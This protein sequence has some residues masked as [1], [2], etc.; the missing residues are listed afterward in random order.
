MAARLIA[1]LFLG[2]SLMAATPCLPPVKAVP[3][4]A[5]LRDVLQREHLAQALE[6]SLSYLESPRGR[7]D[8]AKC[9]APFTLERVQRTLKRLQTL[10]R[11][12]GDLD[13]LNKSLSSEFQWI[14]MAGQ[15]DQGTVA[16]TG[17]FTPV[18]EASRERGGA[19]RWPLYSR[20]GNLDRWPLPHP[21]R[22][23]LEG[24]DGLST[25]RGKLKGLEAFWLKNRWDAY[26]IQVQGSA[27]LRMPDGS[28]V[29]V[30]FHGATQYPYTPIAFEMSRDRKIQEEC[31]RE[32][33]VSLREHFQLHPEDMDT[34][35]Q[36]NNRFVFFKDI[37]GP[38]RGS[39]GVP[40]TPLRTV[41][42]DRSI[43]PSGLPIL[44]AGLPTDV[45]NR[46][47]LA[48]DSGSAIRGPGRLD[49][50]CG[51]GPEAGN[52]AGRLVHAPVQAYLM[53]I[54]EEQDGRDGKDEKLK[55]RS[56]S[57]P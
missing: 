31:L 50:Y 9:A 29:A 8:Y 32:G 39:L 43:Y 18:Y 4:D 19:Y 51:I 1:S 56:G 28:L 40:V 20:P 21:T 48:Q 36:R 10:L 34:Y 57:K 54:R 15:D 44:L 38:P 35:V 13:E 37:P 45:P 16:L 46:L 42:I 27:Q 41:A 33:K 11:R 7:R 55:A 23:E 52:Q 26:M 24:A 12:C 22:I 6:E 30:G 17:Y 14:P 49:L 5:S 53:L 25:A 2:A 3:S 47:V